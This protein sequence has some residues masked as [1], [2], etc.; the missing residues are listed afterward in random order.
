MTPTAS[1]SPCRK[2]LGSAYFAEL[3][4]KVG[5]RRLSNLFGQKA[6]P[7]RKVILSPIEFILTGASQCISITL[8]QFETR[9]EAK[10]QRQ[11]QRIAIKAV[12]R[13]DSFMHSCLSHWNF[14]PNGLLC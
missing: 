5:K 6:R 1:I 9:N 4:G 10:S 11:R 2:S 14:G 3:T 8:T 7:K 13:A 12:F